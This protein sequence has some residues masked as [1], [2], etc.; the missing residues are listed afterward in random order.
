M[1]GS[2]ANPHK[3]EGTGTM[4]EEKTVFISYRRSVSSFMARAIFMDL[5]ANGFDVFMDVENIAAG[6][7]DTIILN[8]IEARA[9]FL[10]ILTPGSLDRCNEAN[11]WL[12]REIET[13][14]NLGRNIVPVLAHD[15]HFD[16]YKHILTGTLLDLPRF[17]ALD[18]PHNYFDAAMHRLRTKFL[19]QPVTGQVRSTPARHRAEVERKI[20]EAASA[21]APQEEDLRAEE[22]FSRGLR[23][24]ANDYQG[25]IDDYSNAIRLKPDYADAFNNRANAYKALGDLRKAL[26]DYDKAISIN[27]KDAVYFNN[28]GITRRAMGDVDGALADYDRAIDLDPKYTDAYN[29]RGNARKAKNDLNGAMADYNKA[30]SLDPDHALA[31]NNRGTAYKALNDLDAA[32]ADYERAIALDPEYATAYYNLGI[33]YDDREDLDAALEKYSKAIEFNPNY[34]KAF[35]NRGN[36]RKAQG[37]QDGARQ[38]YDRAIQINPEYA[39]AYYNRGIVRKNA[40]DVKGAIDDYTNAIRY[41]PRYINAYYNRGNARQSDGDIAGAIRDFQKY[42][43]LGGGIR[44]GD[45]KDV[46]DRIERLRKQL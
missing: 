24:D 4:A 13:A 16:D 43:D 21:P 18:V 29:N 44:D 5:R 27:D 34:D 28:R 3:T 36:I 33:I 26:A 23:R 41:N 15:F 19:K 35:N 31:H 7:F 42:L 10:L 6:E 17:N 12:R 40:G 1:Q 25:K 11:D 14:L 9:H 8:E 45:Q 30:I 37:D 2:Q 39:I 46:E 32:A 22:Y 20:E 38:D